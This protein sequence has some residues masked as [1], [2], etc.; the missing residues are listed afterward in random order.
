[1]AFGF[2]CFSVSDLL[3]KI[4]TQ[5]LPPLQVSW[6]RQLGL[7]AGVL[8]VLARH[9]PRILRTRR[10]IL[11]LGRGLA[12][13][14]T[15][16]GFVVAIAYVPL[17]DA[18]AVGFATPF[19]VT[20][21]AALLLH[22][23][24][25]PHRWAAV[26]VGFVG[27]LM[28]I[29]PGGGV[30]HPAILLVLVAATAFAVR[31]ILSRFLSSADPLPTTIAWTGL[32]ASLLLTL[33]LPWIWVTPGGGATLAIAFGTAASAGLAEMSLMRALDR[34]PAAIVAPMQYTV[35]V[36]ASLFGGLF[37]HQLPDGWTVA[38]S[39]VIVASGLYTVWRETRAARA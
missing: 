3:A 1:M 38:G 18:V 30:F 36:W 7:L 31:Q 34:T 26:G 2:F 12:A 13:V 33:T 8:V 16:A 27:M 6:I 14:T 28:V 32:T 10:P 11:Q 22:E 25:G 29:R 37:F 17:A 24:I 9:G 5:T 39:A 4:L 21:L 35:I 15:S 23:R 19:I 20:V